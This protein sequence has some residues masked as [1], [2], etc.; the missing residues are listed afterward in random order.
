ST[1]VTC[2]AGADGTATITVTGGSGTYTSYSWFAVGAA[3]I[4][5]TDQNPTNLI[6]DTYNLTVIDDL[7]CTKEFLSAVVISQPDPFTQTNLFTNV[8]CFGGADGSATITVAGGSGTYTDFSW[9]AVGA[10]TIISTDQNP[11]NLIADTYNLTVTD[12]LG[13]S[14]VLTSAVTISEPDPIAQ[15]N[16][17]TNV[18]CFDG[19][20]GSATITVTGGS[21]T[22]TGYSW[23]AVS[24]ATVISTDQNPTNLIA[25]TYNL[26]I[27]DDNACDQVFNAVVIIKQPNEITATLNSYTNT[28]CF[29][30]TDGTA[31]ITVAEGTP[32]YSYLWTG[33]ATGHTSTM[34]DPTDLIADTYD[35]QVID[36]NSCVKT[37]N[38]IVNIGQPNDITAILDGF[39][40]ALCFGNSDGTAQVTVAEGTPPYTFIWTGDATGHTS[41]MDNPNDL[42][43][44]TYNL[45]VTDANSYIKTFNDIVTIAEPSELTI[46]SS[47]TNILCFGGNTGEIDI[48][49]SGGTL[50]YTYA[51]TGPGT[52]TSTNEDLTGLLPGDYSVIV[53][54]NN[55]CTESHGPI[56]I[57]Q[58]DDITLSD[59]SST[60]VTCF[61][62]D[63]G[64]ASIT[65]IGGSGTYTAFSWDGQS[66]GHNSTDENPTGLA[67]DIYDLTITDDNAC[68]KVLTDLIT[69]TEPLDISVSHTTSD[70]SCNGAGDGAITITPAGGTPAY[71]YLWSGPNSFTSSDQ[72]ISTLEAGEYDL[73]VTDNNSCVKIFAPLTT[74]TEP[75]E[76]EVNVTSQ[77]NPDCFGD[78]NGTIDIDV[79]EGT[80]PYAFSWTN[81]L[82]TIVSADEDPIGL[83]AATYSLDVTDSE[84]CAVS[85]PNI[86]VLTEPALLETSLT[87]TDILC[88]GETNGTITV[89]PSG[90]TAPYTHSFLSDFSAVVS[91]PATGL[92]EDTY[93]V[94]TRDANGCQTSGDID[95]VEPLAISYTTAI[96]EENLC[97]GD[98]S[99][100]IT[101]SNVLGGIS[102]YEFSVDNGV[103]YQIESVF[104]KLPAGSYPVIVRDANLCEQAD[105]PLTI[106]EPDSIIITSYDQDDVSTCFTAQEGRIDITGAGGTS[107][108]NYSLNGGTTQLSG[109]FLNITGGIYTVN[110]IDANHCQ[111]DTIVELVRPEEIVYDIVNVVGVTGCTGDSNGEISVIGSGGTGALEYSIDGGLFMTA[112]AYTGL[113]AGDYTITIRDDLACTVDSII[114]ITEPLPISISSETV[115]PVSCSGVSS[116]EISV[117]AEN[118]TP[119]Y[120]FSLT[121][122]VLP[123][124]ATGDFV[125]LPIGNYTITV[126][127]AEGCTAA[128]SNTLKITEPPAIVH[129]STVTSK[130]T[131][132]GA[133]DGKIAVYVSGGTPPFEYSFDDGTT[134]IKTNSLDLAGLTPGS[135]DVSVIDTN[136]CN[137]FIDTYIIE[138]PPVLSISSILTDVFPCNGGSSGE[139]SATGVGGWNS[140][141]YSIDGLSFDTSGNFSGL[142][143]G[144]Y[145]LFLRDTGKCSTSS[146]VT[147]SEPA[148][149]LATVEKTDYIDVEQGKI[150]ISNVTGGVPPYEYSIDGLLGSFVS[151]TSYTDVVAGSYDVVVKDASGCTF[152]VS[153]EISDIVPL[154]MII[155]SADVSCFGLDDG[156]IEFLPQDAVGIVQYS[157][158]GGVTFSTTALFENLQGNRSYSL[159][160]VDDDDKQYTGSVYITE[161]DRLF[162]YIDAVVPAKCNVFSA[163][164]SVDLRIEGG[165]GDVT[166]T[167]SNGAVGEDANGLLAGRYTADI[168]D[169]ENCLVTKEILIPATTNVSANAGEDTTICA[170]ETIILNATL[171]GIMQWNPATYLSNQTISNPVALNV[172]DSISYIFTATETSSGNNC[173]NF[174]TLNINILPTY[175]LEVSQDSVGLKGQQMQIVTTTTG[176]FVSYEWIPESGLDVPTDPNP[177]AILENTITYMLLATN[178]YGCIET[179][180]MHIEVV[181][182]LT[183]YNVFSPNGDNINDYFAIK[184]ASAFPEII[185]KIFNRWGSGVFTSVGYEDDQRWDG[186]FNGRELPIGTYYYV[187]IPYPEANSITGNVTIIR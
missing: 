145:T 38:D 106:L 47:L 187:I 55:S 164:G 18:S 165:T 149:V 142:I 98:S 183:V 130:I 107:T 104:E 157:I 158:D 117:V 156:R 176:T 63:N 48:S 154:T 30:C 133:N 132:N 147:I 43:A 34:E 102:P 11:I 90:G 36:A 73:T 150:I 49:P 32:A 114:S 1:N 129:D 128:I 138:E 100:T 152:E 16:L 60:N 9:F 109:E 162:V 115:K 79:S 31:Q 56:T 88:N 135:Y 122:A 153:V 121:P 86:A 39:T 185:V 65:V 69:I 70:I 67:P 182:D 68:V 119:P 24:A 167:W 78:S 92:S 137:L 110:I 178:D 163:T 180:S 26:T 80:P 40:D 87:K 14:Q 168:L 127:D 10:A 96:S 170:G 161:P 28:T 7:G 72:N 89:T 8:S 169:E 155:D 93:T 13:C 61:G 146:T 6:A 144:D 160:A 139:I 57:N 37:F 171:E 108:L 2:N 59:T 101:F 62:N 113:S 50:A 5:S 172:T 42:V 33:D 76:I 21:G 118:G 131:C 15:S 140:Y 124:Q 111:K 74:I 58:A 12:D 174:D 46:T 116:G 148:P 77:K 51:W 81:S 181:E 66:T 20:D 3:T 112:A 64:T 136:A 29:G 120:T 83:S 22:Y 85:Y 103:S 54:D 125:G 45:Q 166:V 134:Y 175:G 27:T 141:E 25:D 23:L 177:T 99:V 17:S 82:G 84:S 184:N 71:T 41:T 19:A 123:A 52:F 35:L 53:T 159:K 44:D 91:T 186:T 4:I 75:L 126:D 94:H 173:Y 97:N 143:A 151:D 179:D 95:I 105:A